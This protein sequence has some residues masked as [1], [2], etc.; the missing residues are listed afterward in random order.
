MRKVFF[1]LIMALSSVAFSA[2]WKDVDGIY[3]VTS[4]DYL[5]SSENE[6]GHTHYRI[7]LRGDSAKD[8]YA[9]MESGTIKDECT[10]ASLKKI[11]D[12]KCLYFEESL[13]YECHFSIDIEK[14]RIEYGVAC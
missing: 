4:K 1:S 3:A 2:N 14:Q 13:S 7:Q 9:A 6:A 11:G 8:L 12:M 10:G 5:D